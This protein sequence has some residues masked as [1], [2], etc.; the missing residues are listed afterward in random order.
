M[1]SGPATSEDV[2]IGPLQPVECP[3]CKDQV[4]GM[5]VVSDTDTVQVFRGCQKCFDEEMAKSRLARAF[6][7]IVQARDKQICNSSA[8]IDSLK[9]ERDG[10]LEQIE[11]L[12]T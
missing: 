6:Y 2:T 8:E 10:L 12:R 5:M 7:L 3:I 11:G 9:T 4:H 1:I